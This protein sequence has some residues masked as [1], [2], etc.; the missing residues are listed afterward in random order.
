MHSCHTRITH[1][2]TLNSVYSDSGQDEDANIDKPDQEHGVESP[3]RH[4]VVGYFQ[5]IPSLALHKP[6]VVCVINGKVA[7]CSYEVALLVHYHGQS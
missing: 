2:L 4:H 5:V 3:E 7:L 1:T 6:V